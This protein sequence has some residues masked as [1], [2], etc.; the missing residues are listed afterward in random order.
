MQ[1]YTFVYGKGK[2]TYQRKY[3][4][5]KE[6]KEKLKKYAKHIEICEEKRGSYSKQ[7]KV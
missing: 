2:T 5:L 6:N 7:I 1:I 3:E 4:G